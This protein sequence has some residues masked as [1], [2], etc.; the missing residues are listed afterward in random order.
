MSESS[1]NGDARP[2][3]VVEREIDALE[4]YARLAR[5]NGDEFYRVCRDA[6]A[7]EI[8]D[9]TTDDGTESRQAQLEAFV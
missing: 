3:G 7:D 9:L 1:E 5:E 4:K 8:R 6:L 2:R